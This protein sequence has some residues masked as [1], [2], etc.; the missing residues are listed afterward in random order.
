[1]SAVDIRA[2]DENHTRHD[3]RIPRSE[4]RKTRRGWRRLGRTRF[5]YVDAYGNPVDD[6]ELERIRALAIPPAWTDVWIS[7]SPR[8]RVQA[9]GIDSAGRKQYRYRA[10]FRAAQERAKFDR[11]FEF[12]TALPSLR[13]STAAHLRLPPYEREWT[14]AV[15]IGLVNKAWFRVGSDR[16]ARR[17]RTYGV[18][19]LRKRHVSVDA[20]EVRFCFRAK[21]RKLVRRSIRSATLA[22]AVEALLD[23]PDGSRLFRY[24]RDDE[25]VALTGDQLNAY[26]AERMG[27]FT[28]KDFRTWGGT[29][30][31]ASELA[32]R[33][34]PDSEAEAKRTLASVMRA[35]G[36]EL[37]NTAAVARESYV[38]PVVVDAYLA[39][40]T[41]ADFRTANGRPA[42]LTADERALVR[43]LR[44]ARRKR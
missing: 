24:E 16:H 1:M 18:T 2:R 19:T 20:D 35:V 27:P 25:L 28:V 42:R 30:L 44:S 36:E 9:T 14:C 33:G 21:N 32:Q 13:A 23:L 41:L 17:S 26:L 43:L 34:L 5:R 31:A 4:G 15:A 40:R 3:E 22:R 29:L 11:L 8:A 6:E 7:P 38:S 10:S 37:G 12:A 39:G